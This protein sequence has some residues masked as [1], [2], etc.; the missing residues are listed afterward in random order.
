MFLNFSAIM[1]QLLRITFNNIDYTFQILNTRPVSRE[2]EEIQILLNGT[3]HTL[4]YS[5][6]AWVPK[7]EG[8][9]IDKHLAVA[10]GKAIALRY[11]I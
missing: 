11:R 8:G 4:I 9:D 10:I 3:P 7:N 5:Q 6:H 2:T 1:G